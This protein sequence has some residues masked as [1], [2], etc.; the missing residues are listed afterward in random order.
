[1]LKIL[2][3]SNFSGQVFSLYSNDFKFRFST[4]KYVNTNLDG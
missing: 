4:K 2:S 3:Q 1:M